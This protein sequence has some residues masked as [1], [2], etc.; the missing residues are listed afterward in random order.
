MGV[1]QTGVA[2]PTVCSYGRVHS[3]ITNIRRQVRPALRIQGQ[4][5]VEVDV[6][7]AQPLI[8]GF[9]V[10]KLLAGDWSVADVKRLGSK[11]DIVEPFAGLTMTRWSTELPPDVLDYI[12]TCERG[13]FYQTLAEIW[14]MPCQAPKNKIKGLS[15]WLILFGRVRHRDRRWIAFTEQV[16]R[17]GGGDPRAWASGTRTPRDHRSTERV[18][19]Y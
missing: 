4:R 16:A 12:D 11:G 14:G 7:C 10:A 13:Q 3:V 1:I 18:E 2:R 17:R 8:L 15:Y 9:M 6:S 5:L 19:A